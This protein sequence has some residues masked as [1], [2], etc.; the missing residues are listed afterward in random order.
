MQ[1]ETHVRAGDS[2]YQEGI[3][4]GLDNEAIVAVS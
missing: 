1:V 3:L 4:T 2:W